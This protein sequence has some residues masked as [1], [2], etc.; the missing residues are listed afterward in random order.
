MGLEVQFYKHNN[1]VFATL[2]N[3]LHLRNDVHYIIQW[4]DYIQNN[5]LPFV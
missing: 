5:P 1:G 3:K 2:S 4:A